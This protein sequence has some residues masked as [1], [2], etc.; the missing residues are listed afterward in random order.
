MSIK[1]PKVADEESLLAA[2]N[3]SI[4]LP[5]AN[6]VNSEK[7][8]IGLYKEYTQKE[9]RELIKILLERLVYHSYEDRDNDI[10]SISSKIDELCLAPE[11]TLFIA[12]SD[13]KGIDGSVAGLYNLKQC[14]GSK[15]I[16]WSESN[17]MC[18]SMENFK[19]FKKKANYSNYLNFVLFDDFIGTGKTIMKNIER[20]MNSIGGDRIVL[21]N[22]K[23]FS[24]VGMTFGINAIKKKYNNVDIFCP[25]MLEKGI[26]ERSDSNEEHKINLM[27]KM[28]CKLLETLNGLKI[29]TFSLGYENSQSLYQINRGNCPNNVFPIFW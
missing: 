29:N 9:E 2:Y 4:S 25:T 26:E 15:Q 20:L 12:V 17:N 5:W 28:E 19:N 27:K 1:A 7:A 21:V 3:L 14:L 13:G 8:L 24:F 18:A 16:E 6:N 22:I 23:V 10:D 11:N